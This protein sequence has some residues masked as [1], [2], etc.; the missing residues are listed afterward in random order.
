MQNM[1]LKPN[2]ALT[3]AFSISTPLNF[4]TFLENLDPF[5]DKSTNEIEKYLYDKSLEIEP[6][7][8]SDKKKS[9]TITN[10]LAK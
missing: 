4:Q 10:I 9:V 5:P 3:I 1:Y 6:R 8:P 2:V 7:N